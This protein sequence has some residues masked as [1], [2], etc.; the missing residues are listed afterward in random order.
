ML[1][2]KIE[3]DLKTAIKKKDVVRLSV[4]RLVK[5]AISNKT[6]ELKVN[7]LED[8]DVIALMRKDVKR[9][10]DSIEQFKKGGRDDLV[11]KEEAEL[12]ILKSYLP[13]E[14]SPEEIKEFV[15]KTIQET[16]ASGK[17]DFGKVM[18]QAMEKFKG[19]ADGKTVSSIV[20]ELL[21][22]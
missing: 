7:K 2:E 6:I 12:I 22:G 14:A 16:G 4:L 5:A 19:A 1:I 13:K 10:L 11:K 9:H 15:K 8:S 20:N 21:G 3:S 17:K 18:K